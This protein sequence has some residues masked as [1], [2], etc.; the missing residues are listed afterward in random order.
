ARSRAD[1]TMPAQMTATRSIPITDGISLGD[2]Q[3]PLFIAGPCVI[4]SLEHVLNMARILRKLRDELK[5]NLVFKSSFDK[6]NRSSIDSF[7][8][9]G[10]TKGLE[11]L[12]A[13]KEET[14]FPLTA[15]TH[16][17]QQAEPAAEVLDIL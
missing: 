12:R 9:P 15:D 1:V 11:L 14:G 16:E 5:I 13:A 10:L 2:G 3:P 8:G 7:R 4:E 6:A 17:P